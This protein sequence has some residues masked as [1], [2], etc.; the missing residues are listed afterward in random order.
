[1]HL[2]RQRLLRYDEANQIVKRFTE[3]MHLPLDFVDASGIF[4]DR[5]AG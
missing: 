1:V 4:L 3:K 5:L 2:R